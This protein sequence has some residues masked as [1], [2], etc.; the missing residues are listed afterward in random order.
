MSPSIRVATRDD[1]EAIALESMA[2]IEHGLEW[3]WSPRRVARSIADPD[4]NVAVAVEDAGMVGFGIMK[5]DDEVAHLLLFAVREDARRRGVGT[6]ILAW[7]ERVADVAGVRRFVVE[8]RRDNAA[9]GGFY[10]RHGYREVE[11]VPR[12]YYGVA[13]GVRFEKVV[14]RRS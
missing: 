7:L 5:Y 3:R 10:R 6:A 2:E 8:A 14:P 1:A 13:D 9:A 11:T 4:T 12:M